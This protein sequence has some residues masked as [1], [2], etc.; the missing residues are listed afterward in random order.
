MSTL[1]NSTRNLVPV[2]QAPHLHG[3]VQF[4][5]REREEISGNLYTSSPEADGLVVSRSEAARA[6]PHIYLKPR[7]DLAPSLGWK[8]PG[9]RAWHWALMTTCRWW[10]SALC[11]H[12][13]ARELLDS[14]LVLPRSRLSA[15]P[16]HH[17]LSLSPS[18]LFSF[19]SA[20]AP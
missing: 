16:C 3:E 13:V 11:N 6:H 12:S 7:K 2:T 8:F 10:V 19:T 4:S 15:V 18:Y 14:A 9:C 20:P 17:A 1:S 5:R